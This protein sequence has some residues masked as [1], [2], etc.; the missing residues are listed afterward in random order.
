MKYEQG[1][2]VKEYWQERTEEFGEVSVPVPLCP[3]KIPDELPRCRTSMVR[4]WRL[5]SKEIMKTELHS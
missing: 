5:D 3:P 4:R 1:S 2:L